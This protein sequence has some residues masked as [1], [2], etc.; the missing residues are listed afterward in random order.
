MVVR[1][2]QVAMEVGS[3][4]G[5]L[6]AELRVGG[7]PAGHVLRVAIDERLSGP[8]TAW[9]DLEGGDADLL[10]G[11]AELAL[12]RDEAAGPERRFC[13]VVREVERQ[14]GSGAFRLR[15]EP[16][17]ACLDEERR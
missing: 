16:G 3:T 12:W 2:G 11:S 1:Q 13:G 17:F 9:V 14:V 15:V 10:G 7:A 5:G 4:L 8:A 6:Q